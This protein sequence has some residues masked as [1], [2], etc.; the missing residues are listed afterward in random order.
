MI[1]SAVLEATSVLGKGQFWHG[2][3]LL[4]WTHRFGKPWR[5]YTD[6]RRSS[7]KAILQTIRPFHN[8]HVTGDLVPVLKKVR[9]PCLFLCFSCR[10][11]VWIFPTLNN[12]HWFCWLLYWRSIS[13]LFYKSIIY[14]MCFIHR[15]VEISKFS[16]FSKLITFIMSSSSGNTYQVLK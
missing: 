6:T 7:W 13:H 12:S 10:E 8:K 15:S 16:F 11:Y 3:G 4:T 1:V 9:K 14:I 2:P 5:K